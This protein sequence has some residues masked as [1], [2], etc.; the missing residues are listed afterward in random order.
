MGRGDGDNHMRELNDGRK[1]TY[2]GGSQMVKYTT[3]HYGT[4]LVHG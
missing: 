1:A 3:L 2:G 4:V